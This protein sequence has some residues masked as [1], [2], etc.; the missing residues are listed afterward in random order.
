[1]L[2]DE[3]KRILLATRSLL[4]KSGDLVFVIDAVSVGYWP[5]KL[6]A[7]YAIEH[8]SPRNSGLSP[9]TIIDLVISRPRNSV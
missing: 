6:R 1:M 9:G 3:D 8:I 4:I 7:I 5:E 2:A